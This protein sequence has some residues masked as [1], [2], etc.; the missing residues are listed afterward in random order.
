MSN[1]ELSIIVPI[2]KKR[3]FYALDSLKRQKINCEIIIELGENPSR[4]RNNG[5]RKARAPLVAF[6]NAHSIPPDDWAT[7]AVHFFKK[8]PKIDIFGGPQLTAPTEAHF[9][10]ISGYALSSIF[11][12]ADVGA[13]YKRKSVNFNANEKD[14]TSAN[15]ICKK[16]VVEA[17]NFDESLW[18]GEDPKFIADAKRAGFK[19]AYSPELFIYHKRRDNMRDFAQQIFRYGMARPQKE[20]FFETLR[21]PFFLAPFLFVIYLAIFTI[22]TFVNYFF[23][24]PILLYVVLLIVF[25]I[26]ECIKNNDLK[27]IFYLPIIFFSIHV[28]YGLGFIYGTIAGFIKR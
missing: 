9:G 12:V 11:G 20:S 27:A 18:P 5:I 10:K 26:H 1:P 28:F 14:L 8:Y 17:I 25:S 2:G 15:L 21:K 7:K 13:R 16:K 23:L 24:F 19:A 22:L 4:N 3:N 6:I